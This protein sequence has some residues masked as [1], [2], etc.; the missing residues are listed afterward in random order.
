MNED[1]YEEK[2]AQQYWSEEQTYRTWESD[3]YNYPF[4]VPPPGKIFPE[5]MPYT[6]NGRVPATMNIAEELRKWMLDYKQQK[7]YF[8]SLTEE[9]EEYERKMADEYWFEINYLWSIVDCCGMAEIP[10]G[11]IFFPEVK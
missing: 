4:Y 1:F 3:Y 9:E 11:F 5:F 2:I 7:D 6:E 8:D 10:N